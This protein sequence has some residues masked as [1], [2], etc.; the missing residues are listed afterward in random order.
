[1]L[2]TAPQTV[3]QRSS[4]P[5]DLGHDGLIP[6]PPTTRVV[7]GSDPAPRPVT[8]RRTQ[9]VATFATDPMRRSASARGKTRTRGDIAAGLAGLGAGASVAAALAVTWSGRSG[10]GGTA[11]LFGS[12]T[13][14]LGTYLALI[15]VLLSSRLPWLER[16]AGHDRLIRWHRTVGPASLFLILAHVVLTTIGWAQTADVGVVTEF[17]DLVLGYEWM[18]P[19]LA[20]FII[21]MALGLSSWSRV[22]RKL[23]YE[24]W[25][26]AHLYFY[27]A[28]L[29]AYGHAVAFGPMFSEY[30]AVAV[31]WLALY[32]VVFGTVVVSR[33]LAPAVFSFRHRLVV[34]EV[35][36]EGPGVVSVYMRGRDIGAMKASGGQ[37]FQWRFLTRHLW[38]QAHPY[39]LS[40]SPS[41]DMLRI[42]VKDLG[43]H[44]KA[45]SLI[46]PGTR[47]FAEGPYGV[48]VAE[49]RHSNTVV[50][51]AAGVG[52][53]P[54]RAL[55]DDLPDHANVTVI[56]RVRTRED[57]AL[58]QEL[59]AAAKTTGWTMHFLAGDNDQHP[60]TPDLLRSLAPDIGHADVYVCGPAPFTGLVFTA[61]D[62]AGVRPDRIH[63]EQFA[64]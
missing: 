27:V 56:Y 4:S 10:P 49:K 62:H 31:A 18:M 45:L 29:L 47:V 39:S 9:P 60:V 58:Q 16:E 64:F 41:H 32:V 5:R 42:T 2:P 7:P 38:W 52:I 61:L 6:I 21:M 30:R 44:S 43:D 59:V 3:G 28:I 24:T 23:K 40:A 14:M 8:R 46:R 34:D 35:I 33:F 25:H 12:V 53:T 13:A 48:F 1:M 51:I 57:L 55:L 37:F 26:V 19:A 11:T 54:I 20:A 22:R 63:H 15:A 50:G 36:P 17:L